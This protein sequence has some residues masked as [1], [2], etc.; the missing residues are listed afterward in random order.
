MILSREPLF[1][2]SGREICFDI[3]SLVVLMV[4]MPV[5]VVRDGK[6]LLAMFTDIF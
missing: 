6:R 4:H 1:T 5:E 3:Q 2:I